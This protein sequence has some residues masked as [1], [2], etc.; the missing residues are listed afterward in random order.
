MTECDPNHVLTSKFQYYMHNHPA[1]IIKAFFPPILVTKTLGLL[2]DRFAPDSNK[3][4]G[5]TSKDGSN[6]YRILVM[7]FYNYS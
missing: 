2:K 4:F 1:L 3:V 7:R 6:N 5:P